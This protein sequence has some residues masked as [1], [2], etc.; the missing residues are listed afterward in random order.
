MNVDHYKGV[1]ESA[2]LHEG[3]A[4]TV[5]GVSRT[6]QGVA[7][8]APTKNNRTNKTSRE[9]GNSQFE[10]VRVSDEEKPKRESSAKY[11]HALEVFALWGAFPKNWTSLK[12]SRQREAAENLYQ[13]QGIEEIK[14]ALAWHDRLKGIEFCPQIHTPHDLDTKWGKLEDFVE[15]HS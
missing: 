13:E 10:E 4:E 9:F 3:V 11:P 15:K 5:K 1:S 7:E 6:A 2:Y 12:E 14:N 8:T